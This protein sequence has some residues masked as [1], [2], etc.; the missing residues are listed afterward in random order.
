MRRSITARLTIALVTAVLAALPAIAAG[1]PPE[2]AWRNTMKHPADTQLL[3]VDP[4]S[5]DLVAV[6]APSNDAAQVVRR[7]DGR[8]GM[9][10]WTAEVG[11]W[12]TEA[13]V[14][15]TA[16]G[17]VL[18][19][20]QG[21]GLRLVT[22][23]DGGAVM[24]E[25][26]TAGETLVGLAVDRVSGQ[27][28]T[29]GRNGRRRASSKT[30]LTSCWT[31]SGA[32]VFSHAWSPPD[33]PSQPNDVAIDPRTHRIYVA[34]TS[35]PL[36]RLSERGQDVVLLAYEA[37]GR[38]VW[39]ARSRGAVRVSFFDIVLDA[40]RG[41]VH[42]LGQPYYANYPMRLFSFTT[43]GRKR[44]EKSWR[45]GGDVSDSELAVT[46]SG[47]VLAV[48]AG[49]HRA[50]LRSYSGSGRLLQSTHVAI[51]DRDGWGGTAR[52]AI[53]RRRRRAH[54]VNDET[55]AEHTTSLYSFAFTGRLLARSG[56]DRAE[57][58]PPHYESLTSS[59]AVDQRTGRVFAGTTLSESGRH[60]ITAYD[61]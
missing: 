27:T 57:P 31:A 11:G 37:D 38:L 6:T 30:W 18:A 41:R 4:S 3:L 42:L 40:A 14:H 21:E 44:F 24:W 5:G 36:A 2:A 17:V 53:D 28:C 29:V 22:L 47:V 12:M 19:G 16:G 59:I 26:L 54:V 58:V 48:S 43:D 10:E 45:D 13:A 23:D 33:G 56:V 9:V 8:T 49:D 60:R 1:Q 32:P 34:G 15:P 25:R 51:A 35:R 61:G 20:E 55:D 52:V 39:T 46:S 7:L 50:T